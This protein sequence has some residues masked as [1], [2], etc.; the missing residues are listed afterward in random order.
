LGGQIGQTARSI[1]DDGSESAQAAICDE[2]AF[3]HAAE[4][5]WIDV[6]AAK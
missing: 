5:V 3:D 6:A 4:H 1:A 2:T